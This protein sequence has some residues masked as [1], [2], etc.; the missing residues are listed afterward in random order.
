VSLAENLDSIQQ[1]IR[2]ACQRAGREPNSVALLAV[3]KTHPPEAVAAAA[4]LGLSLFGE[5]KVQRPGRKSRFAR[6]GCAGISSGICRATSA[7]T[8]LSYSR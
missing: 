1:R 5:N 8:P 3:A 2:A 7:A 6:D 4:A